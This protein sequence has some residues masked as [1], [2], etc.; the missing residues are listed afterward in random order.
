MRLRAH[1]P[2]W[3]TLALPQPQPVDD[4]RTEQKHENARGEHRA[5]SAGRDV[6][7][8][9]EDRDRVRKTGQPIEHGVSPALAPAPSLTLPSYPHPSLPRKRGR[10]GWGR[11]RVG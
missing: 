11:G 3:L 7:E 1:R 2:G 8:D 10:V 9:I 5:A 4:G 6:L